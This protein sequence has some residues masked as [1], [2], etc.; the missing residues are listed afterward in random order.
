M[1]LIIGQQAFVKTDNYIWSFNLTRAD[2][3]FID[4]GNL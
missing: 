3:D 4:Q 1:R 2:L